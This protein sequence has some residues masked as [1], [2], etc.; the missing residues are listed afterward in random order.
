MGPTERPS[1]FNLT[2][3]PIAP[4]S[5]Q[6]V[7][8]SVNEKQPHTAI[9]NSLTEVKSII[10]DIREPSRLFMYPVL[11]Y[12][13]RLSLKLTGVIS[14]SRALGEHRPPLTHK[15]LTTGLAAEMV[16]HSIKNSRIR[17]VTRTSTENE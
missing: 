5:E 12:K 13:L 16:K 10:T 4:F 17:T 3:K 9:N 7:L 1:H 15:V 2:Y 14:M 11:C 8:F 6:H